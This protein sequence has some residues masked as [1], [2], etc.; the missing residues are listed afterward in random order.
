MNVFFDVLD[1]LIDEN[2]E[3]R[4]HA[5]EV[6]LE[7]AEMGHDVY[8]WSSAGSGYAANAARVLGVEDVARGCCPKRQ[9]P[10]GVAVHYA[11]DDDEGVVNEYGGQLVAAYR[12]HPGDAELLRVVEALSRAGGA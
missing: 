5:R 3:P 6:F 7:L 1:T 9:P 4:P 2:G 10:E 12:G 8:L 11:V